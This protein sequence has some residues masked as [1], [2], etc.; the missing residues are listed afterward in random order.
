MRVEGR[1]LS[2]G[3]YVRGM[4]NGEPVMYT[5]DTGASRTIISNRVFQR[6]PEEKRPVLD[7]SMRLIGAG[8]TPIKGAGKAKFNLSL[9]PLDLLREVIV[10]EIEDD[11]LLGY[12]IL[13]GSGDGPADI[14]LSSNKIVL[15]GVEIPV[16]QIGQEKHTRRVTVA[17]DVSIPG[18]TEAVI[19]VYLERYEADEGEVA[20]FVV[21]PTTQFTDRYPLQMAAT[22]VN[23]NGGPT[24][25]VRVMNP[26]TS[27]VELKQDAVIGRAER[28]E[29]IISVISRVENFNEEEN[30][31]TVRRIQLS[32]QG[33]QKSQ[34]VVCEEKG[35]PEH[36]QSLYKR[37]TEG[38]DEHE[39]KRIA[40]LLVKYQD[41]FSKSEWD[42]GLTDLAEHPINTGQADPIKQRP[43]RVPLAYAEEEKKAVEDLLQKGIIRKSTSPWSSPIVLVKKKSGAVRPCVDYR[44]LNAL[45]KPDGFPLPRVQD[46]LDAVAGSSLFSSFDLTSGYFQIPLKKEDIPKSA[47]CCKYGHF[48]MLRLPFGLN[49]A[50]ST[51]QRTM[52]L[53]L[54]GLQWETCLIYIDDIIVYGVDFD[55]H[56][57]RVE[58]VL[59]RISQA[60]LKLRPDKCHMLQTEVVFLGHV[61]SEEGVLPDPTNISKIISWPRPTNNKQVKQFVATGSYY[62]RFVKDFAK[63]ARPLIDLTKKDAVF[64]WSQACEEAFT[65]IKSILT[66]P[67]IMGYPMNEAGT[68][69][70]DTDA[71]GVGIGGVLSQI[72][73]GR[74][75]VIAYAS[76]STN[77]AERNYCI[78]EQELLAVVY[79][80]QYFRQYLLGR[81]FTVRT[82]HQALVWLFSMKEPNGKIAR[83]IEIL[84]AYDFSV[85][86]RPGTKMGHCDA[87]SRCETPSD[88]QCKD[89]DMSEP[90]KCGPCPK[91]RRRAEIM[92]LELKPLPEAD[93]E[94][95]KMTEQN[96]Q[97]IEPIR[98]T[99]LAGESCNPPKPGP[100]GLRSA[101]SKVEPS[102]WLWLNSAVEVAAKQRED[103]SLEPILEALLSNK[104]P[105]S[106][107]MEAASPA[108]RHYWLLWE[109][110]RVVDGV[111]CKSFSKKNGTGEYLQLIAP[112]SL[113]HEI[114]FQMHCTIISGHLGVRRTREKVSQSY[115]WFDLNR[116]VKSFVRKC[117]TCAADKSPPKTPRAPMGHLTSGAP[118]DTLALDYLG[119]LPC[120]DRGNKYI[121]VITDHFTK[122]VEVLAVPNQYAEDCAAR[123][124]NEVIARWGTPLRIHSDQGPTFES[125][126]FREMCELLQVRKSRTSVRNPQG[127]GQTERFNRTLLKMIRA[128]LTG[129]QEDWDLHLGCLAG[130][131]RCTPHDATHLSP[132]LLNLG[133]EIRLPA[134]IVYGHESVVDQQTTSYCDYVDELRHRFLHAHEVAR[135]YLKNSAKRSKEVYD[136]KL[137][138]HNFK[139]GDLVWCLL[140]ARKAGIT[141]KLQKRYEG[142]YVVQEKLSATN[143]KV[144]IHKDGTTKVLHHNKLK[145]Y[146]GVNPQKWV[147]RAAKRLTS[148][149]T[150]AQKNE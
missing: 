96:M 135:K 61:V 130:A 72:Q 140:E 110:L 56:L 102:R 6:I 66:G 81:H 63:I 73:A 87:L 12:D 100:S 74:E 44:K 117:D 103:S 20:D 111:L 148:G 39:K 14:L 24:C 22:V 70:L 25:K 71:S 33:T 38:K 139:Q 42:I 136:T 119:P 50:P 28:V 104:K 83:W 10:A 79:M 11:A 15:E 35:V 116:D 122:Y 78:T 60:G 94:V 43:R 121:L 107:E 149:L 128:Y 36:L 19:D 4:V 84:S 5:A 141:P 118:W 101:K 98:S 47:F 53:A 29:R 97:E 46:C 48:E 147:S 16:T 129:E 2:D 49:N 9:G 144:Q 92:R 34:P 52:E 23:I 58:Q 32:Q 126:I 113:R 17:D 51:F 27:E 82:D 21:E 134:D 114:I 77:K 69:L 64:C 124:V 62:R 41:T 30:R 59:D 93:Q 89:V 54:Q 125:R 3:V 76:R 133:R 18:Q 142:P 99:E 26:F 68:F 127:N 67:D 75:R 40:A 80:I 123:V 150:E 37:S 105:S 90:L 112:T 57:T 146:E 132:N 106:A 85:E 138:H 86:Y 109:N 143:F 95:N 108:S 8:G 115:Y 120:T 45:V 145:P 65:R 137:A 55:Q 91:C 1:S 131:Y 88:C 31:S 7:Q 13:R